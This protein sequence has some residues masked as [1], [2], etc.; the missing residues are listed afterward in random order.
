VREKLL[1]EDRSLSDVL[2]DIVSNIQD[3]MRSEIRLAKTE[4][5]EEMQRR[6]QTS[7][8]L[9]A[10]GTI[11][12]ILSVFFLLL[13]VVY[14]LGLVMPSWGAA[15]CVTLALAGIAVVTSKSGRRRMQIQQSTTPRTIATMKENPEWAKHQ[16]K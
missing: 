6:A 16:T 12:G 13:S 3:I 8:V 15:L 14:A 11:T 1:G 7:G 4:V 9:I 5:R 2:N 10:V